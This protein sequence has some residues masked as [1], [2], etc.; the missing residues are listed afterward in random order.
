MLVKPKIILEKSEYKRVKILWFDKSVCEQN[1]CIYMD[2]KMKC[3]SENSP[4][5]HECVWLNFEGR[6]WKHNYKYF[7]VPETSFNKK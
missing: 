5:C 3:V 2:P 6:K 4:E 1:N 7:Y